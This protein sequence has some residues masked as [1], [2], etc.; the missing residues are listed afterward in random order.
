MSA[1]CSVCGAD[2]DYYLKCG[3]C[4]QRERAESAERER[5]KARDAYM[6]QFQR[7]EKA[8]ARVQETERLRVDQVGYWKRRTDQAEARVQELESALREIAHRPYGYDDTA[9]GL[10]IDRIVGA[11][12]SEQSVEAGEKKPN[13]TNSNPTDTE[14]EAA[15]AIYF[16]HDPE[17]S[18]EWAAL[19]TETRDEYLTAARAA[20]EKER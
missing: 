12:L 17:S 15:R 10:R 13:T 6:E 2:L 1:E 19:P 16:V 7:A 5:D 8:E 20:L 18:V 14:V 11:A 4:E 3:R 9:N